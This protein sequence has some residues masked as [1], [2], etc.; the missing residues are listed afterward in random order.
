MFD[1]LFIHFK[2]LT[3]VAHRTYKIIIY[4]LLNITWNH[5]KSLQAFQSTA[6]PFSSHV[7]QQPSTSAALYKLF[8]LYKLHKLYE[9]YI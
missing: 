1:E 4:E 5:L 8:K 7:N 3:L 6:M 2:K 9:L